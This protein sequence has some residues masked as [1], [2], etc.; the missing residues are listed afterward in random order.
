[1][2][3]VRV[4]MCVCLV[5]FSKSFVGTFFKS[6]TRC[7]TSSMF[8]WDYSTQPIFHTVRPLRKN[9]AL[10][11]VCVVVYSTM[12]F[13]QL[14]GRSQSSTPHSCGL[15]FTPHKA[16]ALLP[17]KHSWKI[18]LRLYSAPETFPVLKR[19][20]RHSPTGKPNYPTTDGLQCK[21]WASRPWNW[22]LCS[23]SCFYCL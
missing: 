19:E 12:Y 5:L 14:R 20:S 4:Y 13:W 7:S 17:P 18:L 8:L 1:M 15:P 22:T 10:S 21:F 3:V 9:R 2:C 6:W 23:L 16:T 11:R